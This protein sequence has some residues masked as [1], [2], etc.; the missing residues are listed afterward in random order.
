MCKT[1]TVAALACRYA[2]DIISDLPLVASEQELHEGL[3]GAFLAF[4]SEAA[5]HKEDLCLTIG[6]HAG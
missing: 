4:L 1:D 2:D 6:S 3:A 5:E